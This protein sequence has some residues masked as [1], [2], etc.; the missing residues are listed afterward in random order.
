MSSGSYFGEH[1]LQQEQERL[2]TAIFTKEDCH[3]LVINR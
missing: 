1:A 2:P 3:F